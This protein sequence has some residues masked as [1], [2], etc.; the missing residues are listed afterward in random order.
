VGI[1]VALHTKVNCCSAV[2]SAMP[3]GSVKNTSKRDAL[4]PPYGKP[5]A[6]NDDTLKGISFSPY[7]F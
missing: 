6:A 3:A 4:A 1:D 7:P 5:L 2:G